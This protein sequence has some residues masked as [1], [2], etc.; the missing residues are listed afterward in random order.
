M[1]SNLCDKSI[2][3]TLH[4]GGWRAMV[5]DKKVSAEIAELH[6]ASPDAGRYTKKLLPT[7]V[8]QPLQRCES[9]ARQAHY[10]M[11]LPWDQRGY[12]LL[13][14]EM[15]NEYRKVV[16]GLKDLRIRERNAL[17]AHYEDELARAAVRLGR[18]FCPADYLSGAQ[19]ESRLVMDYA[20]LPVPD[21]SH[22]V[23]D[24]AEEEAAKLRAAL[25][26]QLAAQLQGAVQDLYDRVQ[27]AVQLCQYRLTL[28]ADGSGRVFRDSMLHRLRDLVRVIPKLNITDDPGLGDM[29]DRIKQAIEGVA[30][31]QLR[32]SNPAF[33]RNAHQRVS[34]EMDSMSE[35]FAGYFGGTST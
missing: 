24:L 26:S 29:C 3:V 9:E 25:R 33:D 1:S 34:S 31:D 11:T 23:A 27:E 5:H 6:N 7:K 14:I 28:E 30:P 8:L 18:M 12:R 21:Q 32:V 10:H 35:R 22:F 13:P 19:L 15:F 4:I 17:L 2:L 20:F 16:D